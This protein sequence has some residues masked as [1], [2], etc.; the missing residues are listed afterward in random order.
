MHQSDGPRRALEPRSERSKAHEVRTPLLCLSG[1]ASSRVPHRP[2]DCVRESF[3]AQPWP[4]TVPPSWCMNVNHQ[5]GRKPI[6]GRLLRPQGAVAGDIQGVIGRGCRRLLVLGPAGSRRLASSRQALRALGYKVVV[7]ALGSVRSRS[8]LDAAVRRAKLGSCF[9]NGMWKLE[10]QALGRRL[11]IVFHD[12]DGC[13]GSADED[14]VVDAIWM[15]AV[16]HCGDYLVV[17]TARDG[18]FVERC[19]KRFGPCRAFVYPIRFSSGGQGCA[20]QDHVAQRRR[21]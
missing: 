9:G 5:A 10:R 19:F 11:A 16:E 4:E 3:R 20:P 2:G 8:D 14:Y 12:L 21:R 6:A 17:F 18:D 7:L 13:S 15:Q 1:T